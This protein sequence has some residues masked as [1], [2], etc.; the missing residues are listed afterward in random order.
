MRRRRTQRRGR[1]AAP[2]RLATICLVAY[3]AMVL[4]M[5]AME[6]QMI[7]YP[8]RSHSD[9]LPF[10]AQGVEEARFAAADGTQLYGW[11]LEHEQPRAV[12]LFAYGNAGSLDSWGQVAVEMHRRHRISIMSFDYRGYGRSA[13]SPDEPGILADARAA[14]MWLSQRTGLRE[15]DIVLAGRSIGGAVMVDLAAADGC[16][17]LVLQNTFTSL[18]DVAA[19]H[20][21]WLPVRWLMNTRLDSLSKI[22]RY[23]GPL[24]VCHGTADEIV[25]Y[26]IGQRLFAAANEPKKFIAI[27]GGTHNE[28]LPPEYDAA[29][30]AFFDE[31]PA[32]EENRQ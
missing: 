24:L 14:R 29:L 30:D 8:T 20:F 3:A 25:P 7:F 28:P 32:V 31:L 2:L 16:R 23:H 22:A 15:R 4:Y 13:G 10:W 5:W 17:A 12:V 11:Y 6:R 1:L 19:W 26:E 18:P 27:A 21:P 9:R